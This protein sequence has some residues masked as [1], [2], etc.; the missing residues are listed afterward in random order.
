[1]SVEEAV[2]L[3]GGEDVDDPPACGVCDGRT[4]VIVMGGQLVSDVVRL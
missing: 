2:I 3:S 1:M 4:F